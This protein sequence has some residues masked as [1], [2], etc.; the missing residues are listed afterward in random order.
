MTTTNTTFRARRQKRMGQRTYTFAFTWEGGD[1]I[2]V[3]FE[4]CEDHDV[5]N[6]GTTPATRAAFGQEI[7]D[8]LKGLDRDEVHE[9][10]VNRTVAQ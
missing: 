7:K 3:A 10:W 8:Y 6:T 1:Y 5:I 9:Y 4:G 2:D